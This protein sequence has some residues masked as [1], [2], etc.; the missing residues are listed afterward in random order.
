M[1]NKWKLEYEVDVTLIDFTE[2]N[3][4]KMSNE[5]YTTLVSNIRMSGLS[6]VIVAYR[7]ITGRFTLISG[8]HR[9]KA[10]LDL[11][12]KTVPLLFVEREDITDDEIV[13]I[14]ISHNTLH[15]EH[16]KGILKELF[17]SINAIDFKKFAYVSSEDLKGGG[18]FMT[19]PP[20]PLKE[21][22]TFNAVLYREDV[23]NLFDVIGTAVKDAEIVLMADGEKN[24]EE[25]FKVIGQIKKKYK[26]L[27]S[28]IAFG[29]LL[30]LA[31]RGL[32]EEQSL[33]NKKDE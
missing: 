26:V 6:S 28:N 17:D 33:Q 12:Y 3:A 24:E 13:A 21:I 31:K 18:D 1:N 16:D 8:N 22:F 4:N 19:L 10:C 30:E 14:Q 27:S 32:D 23:D 5:A 15:G 25:L 20:S 29:K 2:K 7:D 9:F 11:G